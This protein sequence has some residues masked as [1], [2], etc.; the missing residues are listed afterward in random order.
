MLP[1]A[2]ALLMIASSP[3]ATSYEVARVVQIMAI[4]EN[5]KERLVIGG[6]EVQL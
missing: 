6:E 3:L 5:Q 4:G 1:F 2:A